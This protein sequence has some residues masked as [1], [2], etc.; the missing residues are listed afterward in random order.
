[1]RKTE[2]N[3]AIEN[4]LR[5]NVLYIDI[6]EALEQMCAELHLMTSS[7]E[8][9][10]GEDLS[11]LILSGGKRL[12]PILAF[13]S[14]RLAATQTRKD[15]IPLM[16]ML[17]LMHTAS[18][19]HDDVV[20]GADMRRDKP[21]INKLRGSLEAVQSGDF[22][23]SK[24]MK[25]LHIYKGTGIN[26]MLADVSYQMTMG[27][28]S[29]QAM[30]YKFDLQSANAYYDLINKKTAQ[31]LAASCW[32]GMVAGGAEKDKAQALYR[33]GE[34]LGLAFQLR[35]DL[36][37]YSVKSGKTLGQ[38]IRNGTFTLP[39][40]TLLESG[41]P[42]HM[43]GLLKK[44]DKTETE[45]QRV[46][47]YVKET[48]AIAQVEQKVRQYSAAA[49]HELRIFGAG[50]EKKALSELAVSLGERKA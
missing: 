26:E 14:Y 4:R 46:I 37:D 29:Q 42:H 41:V 24:A 8:N 25:L 28:L 39:I 30:R 35:D 3:R 34:K 16:C 44:K 47:D 27:E 31:L 15:I 18:L 1:M 32:C 43:Y 7:L 50:L 36:L 13:V 38:D 48:D 22:L 5:N 17:E 40:L 45:V 2:V 19:I 21:T 23:L 9:Q 49:E 20:D 12:R 33:Y 6:Q 11:D 10:M